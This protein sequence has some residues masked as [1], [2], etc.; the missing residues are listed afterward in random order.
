MLTP[1][2]LLMQT[3]CTHDLWTWQ[4]LISHRGWQF[5]IPVH[6]RFFSSPI[7]HW[8]CTLHL[9][10]L[11]IMVNSEWEFETP[12]CANLSCR[13]SSDVHARHFHLFVGNRFRLLKSGLKC[14]SCHPSAARMSLNTRRKPYGGNISPYIVMAALDYPPNFC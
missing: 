10:W 12:F 6:P 1:L 3:A 14:L 11:V 9:L 5:C 8:S 7:R 4:L 2:A 13:T